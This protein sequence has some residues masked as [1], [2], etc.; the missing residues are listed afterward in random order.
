VNG[1]T[2]NQQTSYGTGYYS[3]TQNCNGLSITECS[4]RLNGFSN[5]TLAASFSYPTVTLQELE[6]SGVLH[7]N[8]ITAPKFNFYP[9]PII[10]FL[11]IETEKIISRV[12]IYN[13][14]GQQVFFDDFNETIISIDLTTVNSGNYYVKCY[15][16]DGSYTFQIQKL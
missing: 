12:S 2:A 8:N 13:T 11:N 4:E 3:G 5:W 14:L 15:S 9:N 1:L 6:T 16:N 10:N 7:I